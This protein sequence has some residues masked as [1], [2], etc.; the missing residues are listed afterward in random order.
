MGVG[1]GSPPPPGSSPQDRQNGPLRLGTAPIS[2]IWSPPFL[3]ISPE[4]RAT[5]PLGGSPGPHPCLEA[6]RGRSPAGPRC[7]VCALLSPPSWPALYSHKP[8]VAQYTHTGLLP[9]T[10]LI[11]DTTNLS[12]LASLTPTKQVRPGPAPPVHGPCPSAHLGGAQE[13]LFRQVFTSDA[14]ASSESG[15]H[16]PV[17]QAT[18][19][20]IPGQDPA[21]IQQLQP[22]HRLSASP[23]GE[24]PCP[25][26]PLLTVPTAEEGGGRGGWG[27]GVDMRG[28]TGAPLK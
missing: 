28:G 12:A 27:G 25:A 20:H 14:E 3:E 18:T 7:H 5:A 1:L 6:P 11:T 13:L 26:P 22:T 10:M 2:S 23:T 9:Q 8:E 4:S 21:G 19:I 17:S 24:P 16:T 15:L